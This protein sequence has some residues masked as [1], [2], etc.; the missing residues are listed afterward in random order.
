MKF[1]TFILLLI[2][3]LLWLGSNGYNMYIGYDDSITDRHHFY[4][5]IEKEAK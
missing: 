3:L 5:T 4:I 2:W 1:S